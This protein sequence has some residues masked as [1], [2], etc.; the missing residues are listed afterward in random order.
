MALLKSDAIIIRSRNQGE[1]SKLLTL[2]TRSYGKQ[3]II[4]KGSRGYKSPY[5]GILEPY[6]R[7]AI[8][9]YYKENRNV[10]Y[11]SQAEIIEPY[12][13][14]HTTL[15]KMALAAIPC[16]ILD[17]SEIAQSA[18][19]PLYQLLVDF[20]QALEDSQSGQKNIVRA[21]YLKFLHISGFEPVLDACSFCGKKQV[22]DTV[23]FSLEKGIYHCT[24][25]CT[26]VEFQVEISGA[27]IKFMRWFIDAPI[28]KVD[29]AK[30]SA[31]MGIEIDAFLLAYLKMHIGTLDHLHSIKYLQQLQEKLNK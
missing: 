6:Y 28:L 25:C 26:T 7:I 10:N 31:R 27:A 12:H 8:V 19:F 4:A 5:L 1:T 21:F 9:F 29:Q 15:G 24:A 13:H 11:L 2:Y 22:D 30:I 17:K 20:L 3:T 18:N 14:I 16:E 23:I